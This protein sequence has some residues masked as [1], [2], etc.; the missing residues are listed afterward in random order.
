MARDAAYLPTLA[1]YEPGPGWVLKVAWKVNGSLK[2]LGKSNLAGV[3]WMGLTGAGWIWLKEGCGRRSAAWRRRASSSCLL[4]GVGGLLASTSGAGLLTGSWGLLTS[5]CGL[6]A[7]ACGLLAGSWG[8]ILGTRGLLGCSMLRTVSST[9]N[10]T[11][12]GFAT[13]ATGAGLLDVVV[14]PMKA[15]RTSLGMNWNGLVSMISFSI[16]VSRTGGSPFTLGKV[17]AGLTATGLLSGAGAL[18][19]VVWAICCSFF[20]TSTSGESRLGKLSNNWDCS[21]RIWKGLAVGVAAGCSTKVVLLSSTTRGCTVVG[22]AVGA[23]VGAGVVVVGG[24]VV[25]SLGLSR[26]LEKSNLRGLC[27]RSV[28]GGLVVLL[29]VV[30]S[31]TVSG[32]V[33]LCSSSCV[34]LRAGKVLCV[35]W[36]RVVCGRVVLCCRVVRCCT[37]VLLSSG[38]TV[39]LTSD[40]DLLVTADT[41]ITVAGSSVTALVTAASVVVAASVVFFSSL[42]GRL[43]LSRNLELAEGRNLRRPPVLRPGAATLVGLFSSRSNS[44][45]FSSRLPLRSFLNL[46]L[47]FSRADSFF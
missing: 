20:S 28:V 43:S 11:C 29:C 8:R 10:T 36:A 26:L 47:A 4:A 14:T 40:S 18:A 39:S 2:K 33:V 38:T 1:T 13:L 21:T 15:G 35:V 3:N 25:L 23:A 17:K 24:R 6:L 30:T 32:T 16:S 34:V 45:S 27:G 42:F 22:A 7:W 12:C 19:T 5:A 41:L 37:V 46:S 9:S 44:L 31:V